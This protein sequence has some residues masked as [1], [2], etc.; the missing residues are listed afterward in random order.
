MC[1]GVSILR[2]NTD[3]ICA[4]TGFRN[5]RFFNNPYVN[6]LGGSGSFQP[7]NQLCGY[8]NYLP[9]LLGADYLNTGGY[10][11]GFPVLN[12]CVPS[13]IGFLNFVNQPL[14]TLGGCSNDISSYLNGNNN[15][16]SLGGC[17]CGLSS[18]YSGMSFYPSVY[19]SG[20][21]FGGMGNMFQNIL[22]SM[23]VGQGAINGNGNSVSWGR[24]GIAMA[25]GNGS[26]IFGN[27]AKSKTQNFGVLGSIAKNSN[28]DKSWSLLN[29]LVSSTKC[30]GQ[31]STDWSGLVNLCANAALNTWV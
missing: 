31:K 2:G 28:G 26:Y 9:M 4:S 22:A 16:F 21:F 23:F 18:L 8:N 7:Y 20:G 19:S 24:N 10:N 29:G 25:S 15:M 14:F 5:M 17:G 12:Y 11:M 27:A 1:G 6:I 3:P 30:S 13:T